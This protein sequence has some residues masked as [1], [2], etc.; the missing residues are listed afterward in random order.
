MPLSVDPVQGSG[1]RYVPQR[2]P[3]A[4][5]DAGYCGHSFNQGL[6]RFHDSVSGPNFRQLCFDAFPELRKIDRQADV[7]AFDWNGKQYLTA[8]VKGEKDPMLLVADIALGSVETLAPVT[9]FAAVLKEPNMPEFFSGEVYDQ[10]RAAV[11]RPEDG[12]TFTDCVEYT[13]PFWLGGEDDL[14]NLQLID[15]DVSWTV[16]AQ[17][18]AQARATGQ[19]S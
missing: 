7:L 5:A 4:F 15:M 16:G 1:D 8:K 11:G 2:G 14:T 19:L 18:L 9:A 6:L 10:W 12:L 3:A 13:T 17:M